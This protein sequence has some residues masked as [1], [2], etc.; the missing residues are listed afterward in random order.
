MA[1]PKSTA[2]RITTALRTDGIYKDAVQKPLY[3][4]YSFGSDQSHKVP[5]LFDAKEGELTE[6]G[7]LKPSARPDREA[8]NVYLQAV[9]ERLQQAHNIVA[10]SAESVTGKLVAAEYDRLTKEAVAAAEAQTQAE[11]KRAKFKE[12]A[13]R[14][15]NEFSEAVI[16]EEI[17][18]R[19]AHIAKLEAE[20]QT[21]RNTLINLKKEKNLYEDDKLTTWLLNY[22]QRNGS[23]TLAKSTQRTNN[24]FV[25][26]VKQFDP[27]ARIGNINDVWLVK[28]QDFLI[29]TPS[30]TPIYSIITVGKNRIKGD[31]LKWQIGK[32]RSNETV[33]NY[34]DKVKS[35]L[36][37]YTIHDDKLPDGVK[38]NPHYK[39]Y[40]FTLSRKP[41]RVYTL[42]EQDLVDLM[43]MDHLSKSLERARLLLLFL[44]ATSLRYSDASTLTA[45]NIQK[46]YI[47]K[48]TQKG[49]KKGTEVYIKIN[50][51]SQYVLDRCENN[52]S[53]IAMDDDYL[54]NLLPQ[55]LK[56]LPSMQQMVDFVDVSGDNDTVTYVPKYEAIRTH[57]GRR[58]HINI[59][60]DYN[61]PLHDIMSI[62]GHK[63]IKTLEGYMQKRRK[64]LREHTLNIFELPVRK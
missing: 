25:E 19:E 3:V 64:E 13:N 4:R 27:E 11:L 2:C 1:R 12:K 47:H 15:A 38:V 42:E 17:P 51:V 35:C 52:I 21:K 36:N 5:T 50:P 6:A 18:A 37:Y 20:L 62:T 31:F 28:F 61:V 8:I 60:L 56:P 43:A 59:L 22:A 53:S 7:Y 49:K 9:R 10:A 46:G 40:E 14:I 45:H 23:T 57:S 34:I 24:S 29:N 16:Y 33:L 39:R 41:E 63:Q 48:A 54:N 26:T 58:T 32:T 30:R 44:C 55:I